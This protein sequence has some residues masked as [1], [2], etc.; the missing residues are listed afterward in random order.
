VRAIGKAPIGPKVLFVLKI[1]D[2]VCL[3]WRG[4]YGVWKDM[5]VTPQ[6]THIHIILVVVTKKQF[7]NQQ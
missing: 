2:D 5:R 7:S 1:D 6:S 3:M 4:E